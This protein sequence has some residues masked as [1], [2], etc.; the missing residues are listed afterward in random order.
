MRQW[1]TCPALAWFAKVFSDTC[2]SF[3]ASN[4]VSTSSGVV[5]AIEWPSVWFRPS[6]HHSGERLGQKDTNGMSD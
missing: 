2:S 3:A 5:V 1:G 6:A 4:K